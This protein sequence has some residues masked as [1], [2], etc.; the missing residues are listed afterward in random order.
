MKKTLAGTIVSFILSVILGII[1]F[2][3]NPSNWELILFVRTAISIVLFICFGTTCIVRKFRSNISPYLVFGLTDI[4]IGL[5][6]TIFAVVDINADANADFIPG[7]LAAI[8]LIYIIPILCLILFI[9][10]VVWLKNR[11]K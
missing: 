1:T 4:I 7:L 9:D 2:V 3:Y 6:A 10:F 5:L 11:N 8:L